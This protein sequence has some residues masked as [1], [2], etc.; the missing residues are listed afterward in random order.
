MEVKTIDTRFT[1]ESQSE[2]FEFIGGVLDSCT[3]SAFVAANHDGL[4]LLWNEGARRLYG[5]LPGEMLGRANWEQIFESRDVLAARPQEI[6]AVALTKGSWEGRLSQVHKN[7]QRFPV[8]VTV[9]PWLDRSGQSVG[10]L[11]VAREAPKM[12][13]PSRSESLLQGV[14]EAAPDAVVI[15][16]RNGCIASANARTESMFGHDRHDLIGQPVELLV[17]ERFRGNHLLHRSAYLQLPKKR[18]LNAGMQLFGLRK[19]GSEFPTEISLSPLETT[20]GT[21]T[22]SFIRDHSQRSQAKSCAPDRVEP[23]SQTADDRYGDAFDH[24]NLAMAHTDMKHRFVRVNDAFVRMFGYSRD[25]LLTMS[26]GDIT[27]PE[28]LAEG[29]VRREALLAGESTFFEI[30]KRYRHKSGR[31]LWALTNISLIR[32][33]NGQPIFYIGQVQD[34]SE[35]KRA[36]ESLR[37]AQTRLQ[38]LVSSSPAVLFTLV[39]EGGNAR[40]NWVSNNILDMMGYSVEEA[41]HPAWWQNNVHPEDLPRVMAQIRGDLFTND[42]VAN[43]FRFRRRDGKY[44]WVRN[45]LRLLRDFDGAPI[46]TVGSWSDLTERKHLEDQFRQ[47][48]KMEAVG[49]LAGGIAHDFNNLLTVINGYSE[50]LVGNFKPGDPFRDFADQIGKAGERAASLTRQLLTFSRR[51]VIAPVAIDLNSLLRDMERMLSRLIGEDIEMKMVAKPDLWQVKV[52]PGQMEQVVMNLVVNARDAMPRGGKLTIETANLEWDESITKQRPDSKPGQYVRLAVSDSGCG[53][54]EATKAR[55]FEPFFTTKEA[56]KGSG[57]GLATVY[58]I[59]KQNDGRIDVYSELGLGTTFK[60]YLP[61]DAQRTSPSKIHLIPPCHQRG[62]ET[63]LLVEDEDGVRTLS[64]L[65]LEKNGYSVIEARN[66]SEGLALCQHHPGTI[67]IMVTDVVMPNMSGRTLAEHLSVLRPKM[68]VLYLSGYTDE[69]IVRH[70]VIDP[71]VPFLQKPFTTDAL[72]KKVREV[73]DAGKLQ[74]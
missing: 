26:I 60:I 3:L 35:R 67:D 64:R 48:Q 31:V 8:D 6:L 30:E 56:D 72:A 12:P 28:D 34:I 57:L 27:H 14:L 13:L 17:P 9:T 66:G 37:Q 5:H 65:G 1:G 42:R 59:I 55:I 74:K 53:M 32:D 22:I 54:D 2:A 71:N 52:D 68:K 51:Q 29:Y 36:E 4:I 24:T 15:V 44:R 10:F 19:D 11:M 16:D 23:T 18:A 21:H 41:L 46:E 45:E 43:E 70:G 69:A 7:G 73:L 39:A 47:S 49:R 58:G 38:Y 25:E 50:L 62:T 20:E 40:L 61:R 33:A 63:V